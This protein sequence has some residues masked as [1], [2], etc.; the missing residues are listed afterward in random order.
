[1]KRQRAENGSEKKIQDPRS[2]LQRSSKHQIPNQP[3]KPTALG[4]VFESW[5]FSG[6]WIL[7][8]EL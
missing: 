6:A 8:L 4:L 5:M 1:M 2:K 7:V 3:A